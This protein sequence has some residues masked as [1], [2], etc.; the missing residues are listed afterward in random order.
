MWWAAIKK[1]QSLIEKNKQEETELK[2]RLGTVKDEPNERKYRAPK[3]R[4]K[5][6]TN[7]RL[8]RQKIYKRENKERDEFREVEHSDRTRQKE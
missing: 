6:K 8:P 2:K 4:K 5:L 7:E 3:K 1:E